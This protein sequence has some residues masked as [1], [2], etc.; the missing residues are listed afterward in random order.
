M[1]QVLN[2]YLAVSVGVAQSKFVAKVASEECKPDGLIVVDI[3]TEFEFLRPLLLSRIWGA[4]P[5]AQ[6]RM[7]RHGFQ[8]IGDLQRAGLKRLEGLLGD[9]AGSH[10]HR[11]SHGL[12]RRKVVTRTAQSVSHERTFDFDM[13]S[14]EE[15][16]QVLFELSERVARRLRKMG[17]PCCGIRV[18]FRYP[19]F[20][21]ATRQCRL[22]PSTDDVTLFVAARRLFDE[23]WKDKPLRLLGVAA[24]V[25]DS[26]TCTQSDLFASARPALIRALDRIKDRHGERA[27][28]FAGAHR[29]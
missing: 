10:Y 9:N 3:G 8:T 5:V 24:D 18:K 7:H 22:Q 17:R 21:T 25:A 28:G 4:G 19:D 23:G 14:R 29:G 20:E 1:S 2:G 11:L 15:C 16:H 27:I 26:D 12:D 6:E 13:Y